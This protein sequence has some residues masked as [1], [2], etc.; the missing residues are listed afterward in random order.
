MEN[1]WSVHRI[2]P[3]ASGFSWRD[4]SPSSLADLFCIFIAKW[5]AGEGEEEGMS[6]SRVWVVELSAVAMVGRKRGEREEEARL[7]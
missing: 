5:G 1:Y 4:F 2:F 6:M 7:L 3:P